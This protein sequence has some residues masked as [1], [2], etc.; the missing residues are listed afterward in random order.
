MKWNWASLYWLLWFAIGFLPLEFYALVS[1]HP[2]W[3]LSDQ[4][5]ALEVGNHVDQIWW[6]PGTWPFG[7]L[8]IACGC[9]WLFGHFV[10]HIWR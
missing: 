8:A 5:W 1:G 9:V 7:H 10:F 6:N 4:V 2:E 3:T